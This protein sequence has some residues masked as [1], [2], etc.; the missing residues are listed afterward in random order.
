MPGTTTG[1]QMVFGAF[2]TTAPSV[3]YSPFTFTDG[4]GYSAWA[5][6]LAEFEFDETLLNFPSNTMVIFQ[7]FSPVTQVS[8]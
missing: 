6:T 5:S 4:S 8:I 3:A 7:P 1:M 2:N